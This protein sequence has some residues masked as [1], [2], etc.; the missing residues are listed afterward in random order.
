[1][2][3]RVIIQT[4][5]KHY[6]MQF[7]QAKV[8]CK[9]DYPRVNDGPYKDT[10]NFYYRSVVSGCGA[11][12]L[13]GLCKEY[14]AKHGFDWVEIRPNNIISAV[15]ENFMNEAI[16]IGLY[17]PVHKE[18]GEPVIF[19]GTWS[20][21]NCVESQTSAL[22]MAYQEEWA[23]LTL[24]AFNAVNGDAPSWSTLWPVVL[25]NFKINHAA[26]S[27]ETQFDNASIPKER[28]G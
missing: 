8:P 27:R 22:L 3:K 4:G 24:S 12:M 19:P 25:D 2:A 13:V 10:L 26:A 7:G 14:G 18:L 15:S 20:K 17:V 9:E 28:E 16:A 21:Y 5:G 1:M 23:A 6:G 11:Q